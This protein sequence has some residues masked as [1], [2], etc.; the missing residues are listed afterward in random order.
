VK[1][2]EG[3]QAMVQPSGAAYDRAALAAR[4]RQL[5]TG[6]WPEA[7]LTQ[8]QLAAALG[9]GASSVSSWESVTATKIPPLSRLDGY[10]TFFATRRSLSAS[11]LLSPDDLTADE[12]AERDRLRRELLDL[13]GSGQLDPGETRSLW[14]FPDDNPVRL[15][16]GELSRENRKDL[17]TSAK[18]RNYIQLQAYADLDAM[19]ELYGHVRAENPGA[20]VQFD[21]APRLE[22][23]D[24]QSHLVMLGGVAMNQGGRIMANLLDLP[25][26]Q[27]AI[28]EIGNGEV[29]DVVTDGVITQHGPEVWGDV[30]GGD[31]I[32][33]VGLFVRAP[34][35]N[36]QDTT[37]TIISG[38]FTRGTY[39]AVRCLTDPAVREGNYQYLADRFDIAK[40][41]AVLMRVPVIDHATAT[42]DLR[43]SANRLFEWQR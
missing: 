43:V 8:P 23:D 29:F 28:P 37:L 9:V 6:H 36:N 16:C 1:I 32:S 33:D 35:P 21:L 41:F 38:V 31:L 17:F 25:V 42:P 3:L 11:A 14:Q 24:L 4:L 5:R 2:D 12:Q 19:V 30:A 15:I 40:P 10:A 26:T 7:A 20:D 13:R 39:G 22:H 34:N 18:R 27:V